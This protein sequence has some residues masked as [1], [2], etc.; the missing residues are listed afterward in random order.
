VL[1]E[2][3]RDRAVD[4]YRLGCGRHLKGGATHA[5]WEIV[6]KQECGR[7]RVTLGQ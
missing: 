1:R 4:K 2:Q 6:E 5:L 7:K 3:E